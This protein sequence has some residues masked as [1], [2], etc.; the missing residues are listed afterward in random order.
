MSIILQNER[1]RIKHAYVEKGHQATQKN[2]TNR[3]K[4]SWLSDVGQNTSLLKQV[5]PPLRI[6]LSSSGPP[7]EN[8]N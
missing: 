2:N 4:Q 3:T 7:T 1:Q 6:S 8:N 5:L